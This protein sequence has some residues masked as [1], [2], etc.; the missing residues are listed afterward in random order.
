MSNPKYGLTPTGINIKRLDTIME[1]IHTD[2]SEGWG[3][4]TRI[5]PESYLN[6]LVT[7][8]ADKIAELWEF[9]QSI[10]DNYHPAS[11]EDAALDSACQYAGVERQAAAQ[12]IYPIHCTGTDGTLLDETT[13]VS[14]N[15]NPRIDFILSGRKIIERASFN[16][17]RLRVVA[18]IA[19]T[20]YTISINGTVFS[21]TSGGNP[22]AT[23]ILQGLADKV[24]AG[25]TFTAEVRPETA[26]MPIT[27]QIDATDVG[28]NYTMLL[29]ENLTTENVTSI[30]NFASI[31][32]GEVIVPNGAIS[33]ITRGP[34]GF[35]S[36]T[37]LCS[38]VAGRSR[39]NDSE[40]RQSYAEKVF[41]LSDRTMQAIKAAIL[42]NVQ[43]VKSVAVY[44]ND[45]DFT[46]AAGRYP[47]SVEVIVDGGS[48]AE[49]AAQ[50]FKRKA[51][52]INTYGNTA[53]DLIGN[54]GETITIRFNRPTYIYVWWHIGITQDIETKLPTDYASQIKKIIAASMTKVETG[55][56]VIPQRVFK[57][58]YANVPGIAYID[59]KLYS[60]TDA[61]TTPTGNDYTLRSLT[62]SDRDL[63]ITSE[64]MIEVALDG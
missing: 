62:L 28:Q 22:T 51:G 61:G 4:N 47:H 34:S 49:I 41:N 40:F 42:T 21:V 24:S 18:L 23:E 53:V 60:V 14:S 8:F 16:R 7:D 29:T 31:D 10:Y 1:E 26:E 56:D 48:P 59:V 50:I 35:K 27:L 17:A 38:Y 45:Q 25:G 5:N 55:E 39:Q 30:I 3:V 19:N 64:A 37:N 13:V 20:A 43:G 63:A 33:I 11:A 6:V 54:N 52:G 46:D 15:T 12:T 2:L 32:Y 44:E 36:C 58:I 9:G 57:Q